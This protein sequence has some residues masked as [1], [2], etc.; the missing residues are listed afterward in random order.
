MKLT[1]ALLLLGLGILGVHHVLTSTPTVEAASKAI[2]GTENDLKNAVTVTR[3]QATTL[4]NGLAAPDRETALPQELQAFNRSTDHLLALRA[5]LRKDLDEYWTAFNV[6]IAEF[7]QE[8]SEI[9]DRSTQRTMTALRE[10]TE[11]DRNERI[12][13]AQATLDHLDTVIS[14]GASLQHAAKCIII[15]DELHH[16]AQDLDQTLRATQ[17]AA[18]QYATTTNSLLARINHALTE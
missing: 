6:K 1:A 8:S 2:T 17:Q 13:N 15:A 18:N 5:S 12:T 10:Q 4:S 3:D 7:D 9:S 14:Q 16:H 11:A